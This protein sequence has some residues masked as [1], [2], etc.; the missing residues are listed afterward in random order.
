M[1]SENRVGHKNKVQ[2]GNDAWQAVYATPSPKP[3]RGR[4]L[5]RQ[6]SVRLISLTLQVQELH[7]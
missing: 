5:I 3:L 4:K 6:Q 7:V 1:L 2:T